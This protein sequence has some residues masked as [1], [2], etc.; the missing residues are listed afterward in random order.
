MSYYAAPV[1]VGLSCLMSLCY[2][3]MECAKSKKGKIDNASKSILCLWVIISAIIG[4]VVAGVSGEITMG[5]ASTSHI[6][7]ALILACV[8]LSISSGVIYWS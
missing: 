5:M 6:L 3:C 4:S 1:Y 7:I 8:T 2:G